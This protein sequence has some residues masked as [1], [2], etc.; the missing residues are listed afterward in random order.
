MLAN[1][2]ATMRFGKIVAVTEAMPPLTFGKSVEITDAEFDL[3]RSVR[4]P[5][6][7]MN[8]Q[9]IHILAKGLENKR[10]RTIRLSMII[11]V[12]TLR[13]FPRH[14]LIAQF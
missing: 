14:C 4:S 2:F 8:S 10:V 12:F 1:K 7:S 6:S 11:E 13:D 9:Y 5:D 3:L